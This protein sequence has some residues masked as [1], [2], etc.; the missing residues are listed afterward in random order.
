MTSPR[1]PELVPIL[2]RGKHRNP[3]RG[4]CF[5]ELASFMAGE[6]W[7]DHP[8]CT[9]PLLA[10]LARLVNDATSDAHRQR[11]APLI[12]DVVGL[13][14]ADPHVDVRIALRSATAALPVAAA[15]RQRVMA[16]GVIVGNRLLDGVGPPDPLRDES[17]WALRHAPGAAGWAE[18]FA[19]RHTAS[20]A[21][22]RRHAA[23]VVVR[24]AVDGIATACI[25]DPDDRLH[26]LLQTAIVETAAWIG[27]GVEVAPA[28]PSVVE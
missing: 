17:R 28:V 3:R 10:S 11:L 24:Q 23:P 20:A 2:S 25:A 12:P 6:R 4:A 22:F 9:H 14:S 7:S 26:D 13:T 8:V 16:V 5:M 15:E 19:Q 18:Q 21:E 1:V 27:R